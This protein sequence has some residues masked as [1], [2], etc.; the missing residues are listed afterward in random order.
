MLNWFNTQNKLQNVQNVGA[1]DGEG[2]YVQIRVRA[3][4]I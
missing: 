3:H 1:R 4:I 2:F